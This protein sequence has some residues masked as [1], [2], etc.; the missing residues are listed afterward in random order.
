MFLLN[1]LVKHKR[2]VYV[3]ARFPLGGLLFLLQIDY[4][5]TIIISAIRAHGVCQALD[6][7]VGAADQVVGLQRVM[8]ATAIAAAL[9]M[10]PF[11][12]WRHSYSFYTQQTGKLPVCFGILIEAR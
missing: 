6:S 12:M 5:A 3:T 11:W 1:Y 8:G 2:A 10:F 9:R 4:F 7:A